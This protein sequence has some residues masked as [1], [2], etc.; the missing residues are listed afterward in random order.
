MCYAN[1]AS[2]W[3]VFATAYDAHKNQI[4]A[5]SSFR[6]LNSSYRRT[7]CMQSIFLIYS[8]R[9]HFC[10]VVYSPNNR[11]RAR[12]NQTTFSK[13]G[14]VCS[15]ECSSGQYVPACVCS[16]LNYIRRRHICAACGVKECTY[17]GPGTSASNG[18]KFIYDFSSA[19][20]H[21]CSIVVLFCLCIALFLSPFC[22]IASTLLMFR[23]FWQSNF[24]RS[25]VAA[26]AF[27]I[28]HF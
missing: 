5:H 6:R 25:A 3:L 9:F 1:R 27:G 21:H 16:N 18:W 7:V 22:N 10:Y 19:F 13:S 14:M 24:S 12:R 20:R 11:S 17:A 2:I 26:T 15:G 4:I 28:F 23:I 8:L